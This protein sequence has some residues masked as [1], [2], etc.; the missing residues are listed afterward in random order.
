MPWFVIDD[1]AHSHP[2]IVA[3]TNAALGLWVRAGAYAAQ[4][5]TDGIV[6]GVIAKMYGSKPQIA[7]LLAAGLWHEAGHTCP[8]PKCLQ[9]QPGDYAIHDYLVYNPTRADVREKRDKAA[10]KKRQQRAARDQNPNRDGIDGDPHAN[11]EGFDD[12]SPTNH[13]PKN[14]DSAGH[15]DASPGDSEG[16]RAGAFPSP[17]LPS[18]E[19][20]EESES[21]AGSRGRGRE[22]ALSLI[23]ADWQPSEDD[24]RGAQLSRSDAGREQLTPQQLAAVTR[25]FVRRMTEDGVRAG[26]FGGRWQQWVERERTEPT[27]GGNVVH[28]PGAMTKGQ[29]Q[30]AGLDRLRQ[31]MNGG[32]GA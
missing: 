5:L 21:S 10:E 14:H 16:T 9:P 30:R 24:V 23:A 15:D 29:Q 19:G 1:S 18:H 32:S 12:D 20:G 8:H 13:A 17:P 27:L 3:A 22:T 25:K 6:P 31:Q 4:H 26:G 28:L 11:R 7:K 2:K